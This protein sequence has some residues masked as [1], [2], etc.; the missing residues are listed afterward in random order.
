MLYH[1]QYFKYSCDT[2]KQG[3]TKKDYFIRFHT[4][5]C[6]DLPIE[7][8]GEIGDWS[9]YSNSALR[10]WSALNSEEIILFCV[11]NLGIPKE[12]VEVINAFSQLYFIGKV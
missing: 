8:L 2:G 6:K 11:Q 1:K 10:G 12:D 5:E 9:R 4:H 3:S 7:K